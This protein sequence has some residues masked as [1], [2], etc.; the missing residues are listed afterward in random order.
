MQE[1]AHFGRESA[2]PALLEALVRDGAVIVDGL[3][4]RGAVDAIA[5]EAT[6][7]LERS[8]PSQEDFGGTQTVRSGALVARLPACRPVVQHPLVIALARKLLGPWCERFHLNV[9]QLIQILPGESSQPLHR[10]RLVWGRHLPREIEPQLNSLWALT[11]FR[12]DNGATRVIPGSQRGDWQCE[13]DEAACVQ[14]VMRAGSVLIYTGSVTHGG[15]ANRSPAARLG[16]NFTYSLAWLR[17]EENQFLS[18]PPELARTLAPELQ[19]LLGYTTGGF[20]LGYWT[21]P[22]LRDRPGFDLQ[23]PEE[24][25]GRPKRSEGFGSIEQVSGGDR[26]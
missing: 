11:D 17:Q 14:A 15:G 2:A 3:L 16:M 20:A 6:P 10:D 21:K 18:C 13:P 23:D 1:L 7:F 24:A 8:T 19:E 4:E 22:S 5:R 26:F 12:N 25:L 9:S